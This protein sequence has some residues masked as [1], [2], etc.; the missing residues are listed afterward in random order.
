MRINPFQATP[1]LPVRV[2]KPYPRLPPGSRKAPLALFEGKKSV[3][4][5]A[6]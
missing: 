3:G 1:W 5:E 4:K 6:L 2:V